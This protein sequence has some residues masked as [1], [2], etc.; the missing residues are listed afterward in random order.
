MNRVVLLFRSKKRNRFSIENVFSNIESYLKGQYDIQ[1][2]YL[3]EDKYLSLSKFLKNIF[4]TLSLRAD[5]IHVTGEIYFCALFTPRK[6]TIMTIHDFVSLENYKGLFR[7]L[8][9]LLMYYLPVRRCKYITCISGKVYKETIERFPFTRNKLY[10]IEDSVSDDYRYVPKA[11]NEK[12]P[13]ILFIG[14]LPHKNLDRVI[15]ALEGISCHLDIIGKT[16]AGQRKVMDKRG[17]KYSCASGIANEEIIKHYINC[18]ILCFPS[19]YEG[20]G[21]P[22]IE[23]Q[24]TGRAVVTSNIEP[25]SSVAGEGACLVDPMDIGAIRESICKIIQDE[26]YRE[27]LIAQGLENSKKYKS[28]MIAKKYM[29]LYKQISEENTKL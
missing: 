22:I 16:T 3:P 17:V 5:V 7:I 25:M 27:K 21:M 13:V 28:E 24:A 23:A 29:N 26:K 18:D 9:W 19:L 11:F 20:F 8:D 2:E 15:R 1:K 12:K 10:L 6:K 4:F 14:S